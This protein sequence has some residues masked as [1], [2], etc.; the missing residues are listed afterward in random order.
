MGKPLNS[1]LP[2]DQ[3]KM[4]YISGFQTG[5]PKK[6]KHSIDSIARKYNASTEAVKKMSRKEEWVK[7]RSEFEDD[8]SEFLLETLKTDRINK[9]IIFDDNILTNANIIQSIATCKLLKDKDG[10]K[11]LNKGISIVDLQRLA[12]TILSITN[13]RKT[14]FA[15]L[16]DNS[17]TEG[18]H[19]FNR[20]IDALIIQRKD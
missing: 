4:D 8:I 12:N 7:L 14:L 3:M 9:I 13:V 5:T 1:G 15:D 11:V 6:K 10:K 20:K 19:D 18:I 16:A 17:K 2:W